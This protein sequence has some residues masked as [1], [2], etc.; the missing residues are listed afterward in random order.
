M[1]KQQALKPQDV[2]VALRLAES[3]EASYAALGFD[4]EMS[5]STAHESVERLQLAG[6]LRP[7]SR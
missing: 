3:P 4:L 2:A 7:E 6:L 5:S 1:L